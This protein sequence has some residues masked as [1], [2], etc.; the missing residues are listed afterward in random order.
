M[1]VIL[2]LTIPR[3][4]PTEVDETEEGSITFAVWQYDC[5]PEAYR[6]FISCIS[7]KP[8]SSLNIQSHVLY[9]MRFSLQSVTHYTINH[10]T[11]HVK[12]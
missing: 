4:A 7:C 6:A 11:H 8:S 5:M 10:I 3:Q 12:S 2:L 1:G 9:K